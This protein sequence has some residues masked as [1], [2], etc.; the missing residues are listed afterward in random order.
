[1]VGGIQL[2]GINVSN[3]GVDGGAQNG[4]QRTK[5]TSRTRLESHPSRANLFIFYLL[6]G[7][8]SEMQM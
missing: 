1:M 6:I 3:D 8:E 4:S 5:F 7:A 2:E